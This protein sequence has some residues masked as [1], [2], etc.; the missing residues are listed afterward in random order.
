MTHESA[1]SLTIYDEASLA[2]PN[3]RGVHLGGWIEVDGAKD[4][5][6]LRVP[7]SEIRCM[8]LLT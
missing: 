3:S 2:G 5:S 4:F 6:P 7:V 1:G 8:A